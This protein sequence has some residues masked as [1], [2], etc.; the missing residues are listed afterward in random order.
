[1][2]DHCAGGRDCICA[3]WREVEA[4]APS[5]A[6][7]RVGRTGMTAT[8]WATVYL[9]GEHIATEFDNDGPAAALLKLAGTLHAMPKDDTGERLRR[10]VG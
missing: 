3:A 6:L 10:Y 2:N 4:I 8:G 1:V 5:E 7:I 9:H